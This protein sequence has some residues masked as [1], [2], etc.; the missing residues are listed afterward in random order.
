[1]IYVTEQVRPGMTREDVTN[2][3][4]RVG[5]VSIRAGNVTDLGNVT[6]RIRIQPCWLP[7][8]HFE[9]VAHYSS[10]GRLKFIEIP[11]S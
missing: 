6:D 7:I 2:V 11:S 5:S 8:N 3:L 4:I 1:M 10:D 9:V